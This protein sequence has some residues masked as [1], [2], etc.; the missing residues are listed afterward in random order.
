MNPMRMRP[1]P[2]ATMSR[3][4][5]LKKSSAAGAGLTLGL[6]LGEAAAQASGPGKTVGAASTGNF[7]PNASKLC[8]GRTDFT[9]SRIGVR[10]A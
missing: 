10:G 4:V 5:F 6:Y 1:I 9:S 7:E 8:S 3:R 2:D